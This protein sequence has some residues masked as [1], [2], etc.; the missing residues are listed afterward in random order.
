MV[1]TERCHQATQDVSFSPVLGNFQLD[2]GAAVYLYE[3]HHAPT[4][5]QKIRPSF[6]KCDHLD[7]IFMVVFMYFYLIALLLTDLD[8]CPKE[9]EEFSK[10][11]MSYWGNFARTGSPNGEGL[12]NWPKYGADEKY[13]SLDLKK[14]VSAQFLKKDNFLFLTKTLPEKI[15]KVTQAGR[16]AQ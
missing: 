10:I 14:Q 1:R 3:Y 15:Q 11:M 9:E 6:V 4:C 2:A 5:L 12:V 7:E 13:L 8:Q 16:I